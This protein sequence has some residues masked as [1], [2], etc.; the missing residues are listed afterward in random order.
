[1]RIGRRMFEPRGIAK[2]VSYR[3]HHLGGEIVMG[4][5]RRNTGVLGTTL[6]QAL[7]VLKRRNEQDT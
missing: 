5:P 6:W 3:E 4:H 2:L 1:M 7:V